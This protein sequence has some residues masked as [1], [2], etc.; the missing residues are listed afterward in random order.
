M[1]KG[2]WDNTNYYEKGG[3]INKMDEKYKELIDILDKY[4]HLISNNDL[5]ILRNWIEYTFSF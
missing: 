5:Q 1:Y 3:G 2:G 4:E